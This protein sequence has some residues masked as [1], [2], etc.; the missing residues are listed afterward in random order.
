MAPAGW[1]P[2]WSNGSLRRWA[3]RGGDGAGQVRRRK[4][5]AATQRKLWSVLVIKWDPD[6][7]PRPLRSFTTQ[8]GRVWH[9][10]LGRAEVHEALKDRRE[11]ELAKVRRQVGLSRTSRV[12]L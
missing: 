6:K 4:A 10:G 1:A 9:V 2:N 8:V 11:R 12:C 3:P 5:D 7:W